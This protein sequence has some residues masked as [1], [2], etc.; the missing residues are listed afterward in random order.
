MKHLN[1]IASIF[2]AAA[3]ALMALTNCEGGELTK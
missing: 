3:F 2:G 1:K